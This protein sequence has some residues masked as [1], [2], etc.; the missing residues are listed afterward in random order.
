MFPK[1]ISS[2][3]MNK[4]FLYS[5]LNLCSLFPGF[6][7]VFGGKYFLTDIEF[8]N[9]V[10]EKTI[11]LLLISC[12]SM[13]L[14]QATTYLRS[15]FFNI[16]N[17]ISHIQVFHLILSIIVF[18][19]LVFLRMNVL[20]FSFLNNY[21]CFMISL[22]V[23]LFLSNSEILNAF[24]L[25]N[26]HI[27]YFQMI[28]LRVLI[29]ISIYCINYDYLLTL[30]FTEIFLFL[31]FYKNNFSKNFRKF[32]LTGL[33][34]ILN[35]GFPFFFV[36]SL[37]PVLL[38]VM[39]YYLDSISSKIV[40]LIGDFEVLFS[41]YSMITY[42]I[43]GPLRII[44][45]PMMV[46]LEKRN[47]NRS[48]KND[49]IMYIAIF[50]TLIIAMIIQNYL[51]PVLQLVNINLYLIQLPVENRFIL[52]FVI[53]NNAHLFWLSK[54]YEKGELKKMAL[55]YLISI[56]VCLLL[57]YYGYKENS[58]Y[59]I[60]LSGILAVFIF[61]FLGSMNENKINFMKRLSLFFILG[62]IPFI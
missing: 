43:M 1:L 62:V 24:R 29:S 31:F 38:F 3:L 10:K 27:L 51:V 19:F 50:L 5:F 2:Y 56:I 54:L 53:L 4:F 47:K 8:I 23:F 41:I 36:I 58:V 21:E 42:L 30:L 32:S 6:L 52:L 9:F 35:K 44:F 33:F 20:W 60:L 48:N 15:S 57:G 34:Q 25:I 61:Y 13:G 37:S 49:N 16:K 28:V 59:I 39:K 17:I 22:T 55:P 46:R 40:G 45:F 7:F 14:S 26:K 11:I 18:P 12:F